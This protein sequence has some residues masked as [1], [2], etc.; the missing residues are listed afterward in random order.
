MADETIQV[1]LTLDT[2]PEADDEDLERLTH[3]LREELLDL[4]V[5]AVDLARAG[6]LPEPQGVKA[7]WSRPDQ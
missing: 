6:E 1:I 3:Q 2:G 4:D 7:E 5:E